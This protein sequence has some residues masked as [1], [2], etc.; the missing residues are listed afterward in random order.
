MASEIENIIEEIEDYL[1]GCKPVPLSSTKIQVNR[2]DM[3]SLID[4]LKTKTPVE[5]KRYQKIIN[6]QEAIIN[7][8]KKKA[9][10][11][12][13]EAQVQTTELLSEH[14][15]MRKAYA[16]AN[17]VV[18]VATKQANEMLDKATSEANEIRTGAIAYTDSLL[19]SIQELLVTS[20]D[21]T[22]SRDERFL[23]TMQGY[24]DTVV[25][26]R[27]ELSPNPTDT[28]MNSAQPQKPAASADA[29]TAAGQAVKA[30][31]SG[32]DAAKKS[33]AAAPGTPAD[34]RKQ[35]SGIDVPEKF[36]NKE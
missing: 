18:M 26:N 5:I 31:Q 3:D 28:V 16:Q 12:I 1:D 23:E 10:A 7:D 14:E 9:A 17:E 30:P 32:I 6:N 13:E 34:D 36:F 27:M 8:A 11:I 21:T 35:K 19:K 29:K 22:R 20:M 25:Q 4:E 33:S 15:I 24:L 2:D